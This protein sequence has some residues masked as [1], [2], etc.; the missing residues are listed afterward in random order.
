MSPPVE[1][2]LLRLAIA[3][4]LLRWEDLDAVAEHLP[5]EGGNGD[6]SQGRWVRA[7]L[8]AGLLTEQDVERL[9]AELQ[10][11][12]EDAT[13][14]YG[15]LPLR[16]APP[17]PSP[18][19]P[20][21]FPPE[22]RF[23]ADWPR[24][25][26]ERLLGSG[27][28][29]TVYKAFDPTLGRWVALKFLYRNDAVHAERFLRE[30]RAQARI[31]HP[32]VCQV[33]EVGEAEGRPYIAMQY[34]D[35]WSLGELCEELT[36]DDKVRLL[37][38]VARA[39]HTAHRNG[40]IHRDLKPGNILVAREETGEIHPYVVDFGL[41]MSQDEISLSRT[42]MI[43]GTPAYISPEQAQGR[44][45][46]RRTDVYSL[47]VVLYELLAGEP[48]FNG[49][50][51]ARVLVRLVQED[52]RPLR[53]IAPAIPED[54]ETIVAKCLEK[55]PARRYESA[56]EMAEDLDRFLDGEPIRA[57]PAGWLYR[58]GKRLRKNRAL[59]VV[60]VAA[61]LS[62]VILGALSLRAEWRARERARLAQ[63]F[64][65][66]IGSFK[67]SMEYV[68]TQPLHDITPYKRQLEAEMGS[69]R[70]EMKQIGPIAE[71]PGRLALGQG[72]LA[73]HQ[74][75][76]ARVE[77]E[78]A[79]KADERGPEV[80]EAL[81]LAFGR[82]YERSLADADRSPSSET[83]F[84]LEEIEHTYRDPALAYLREALKSPPDAS[85]LTG[86]IA[87][88]EG[89][90]AD[91]LAAVRRDPASSQAVRLEARIYRAQG[92]DAVRAGEYEQADRLF[93]QAGE[94][95]GRLIQSFPS[96]PD[97]YLEDC[98]RRT[99]QILGAMALAGVP[100]ERMRE[101]LDACDRTLRVDPELSDALVLEAAALWRQA[102]QQ[103]KRGSDPA[104]R[105]ADAVQRLER[106]IAL[107][108]RNA[109][110]YP[111]LASAHL[112]LAQ[113]K[114]EHGPD[115]RPELAAGIEAARKAVELQPGMGSA[116]S[117]LGSAHL[118]LARYQQR[119][120][121]DPRPELLKA[122]GSFQQAS[123]L[124]PRLLSA[125]FGLGN[126]WNLMAEAQIARGEDPSLSTG[127][128]VAALESA[129]GLNPRS[130]AVY[131]TLGNTHLT[132]GE[133]LLTR[134]DDPRQA[135]NRAVASYQKARDLTP[136]D[137]TVYANLGYTWRS[138]GEALLSQRQDPQPALAQAGAML[139]DAARLNPED[140]DVYLERARVRRVAARWR[141]LRRQDPTDDLRE[142][143]AE[144]RHAETLNPRQA[145]VLFTQA[146]IARDRA[147]T[148][149]DAHARAAALREGL[150][151][152][153]RAL[154][155][156]PREGRYLALRGLLA[157]MSARLE[158]DP[159]RRRE[160]ARQA[161]TSLE[162]AFK[163]NP[164][165]QR[166]YGAALADARLDAR[167]DE[168]MPGAGPRQL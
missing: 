137:S 57:R 64:G 82:S 130:S 126:T 110:I 112:V 44:P 103:G 105:L 33:H 154:A 163:A 46:D 80:A 128:A 139:D 30:A 24:Y 58:T 68:A 54:L 134:G 125:F 164:L 149:R 47:G 113:W 21:P 152:I 89:R 16:F 22:L 17:A 6:V 106:A 87:Y 101:A 66:R 51:L 59:A 52:P 124:S 116:H 73:L 107:D 5:P 29:G 20:S 148:A 104:P 133:Y 10:G 100:D 74:Y 1:S 90:Y 26:V 111:E 120:G 88:Y 147:E 114:I 49:G 166:E 138:L 37:R 2:S 92:S 96:D 9:T 12:R 75:D 71:G 131:N 132:L 48:P 11:L 93:M 167:L 85:F 35:G 62:L 168:K 65:Q 27:G 160:L 159:G 127:R 108:P 143:D 14:D 141:T 55:D 28:M 119:R 157:E 72:Y 23:L 84:R 53:Q 50:N 118:L 78:R 98:E 129:A 41:A 39:I 117:S 109:R 61:V 161:L 115:A 18:P 40:L 76:P 67:A 7:L 56:R 150:E 15:G 136:D 36:L 86:L 123:L 121:A 94:I 79:W 31:A 156:N 42:G 3:K 155:V 81:G 69:I 25:R 144:L 63:R 13:P 165:L 45:L 151:R 38:D 32:N 8:E 77:L 83:R 153:G 158:A 162:A 34:I 145:D 60:S 99:R 140:A 146:Q 70:A 97:L 19:P 43:S 102:V 135:F 4:G 142:A 95:Y 122:A 91:A